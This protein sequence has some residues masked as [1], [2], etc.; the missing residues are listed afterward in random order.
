MSL[1]NRRLCARL[2]DDVLSGRRITRE[3]LL[4]FPKGDH[5]TSV[6]AAYHALIHY[7]ADEDLRKRDEEYREE[8]DLY[9]KSLVDILISGKPLP[10]NIINNYEQFYGGSVLPEKK[11]FKGWIKSLLRFI[12]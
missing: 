10:V 11:G 3:A 4:R 8:Q 2:I 9:L 7:E 6:L 12:T 1:E 5:D